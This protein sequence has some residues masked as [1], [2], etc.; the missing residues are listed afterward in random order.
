MIACV[1]RDQLS[2]I[3]QIWGFLKDR[4]KYW[5]LPIMLTLALIGL[6]VVIGQSTGLGPFIYPF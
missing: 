5:L 1:F 4:K 2:V 3:S 6:L